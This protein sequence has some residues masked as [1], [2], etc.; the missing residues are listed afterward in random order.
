MQ[1]GFSSAG[2]VGLALFSRPCNDLHAAYSVQCVVGGRS[3]RL[4]KGIIVDRPFYAIVF[5]VA[6]PV[7]SASCTSYAST[8]SVRRPEGQSKPFLPLQ[9]RTTHFTHGRKGS[10]VISLGD[11]PISGRAE[12]NRILSTLAGGFGR[13]LT[14]PHLTLHPRPRRH[15]RLPARLGNICSAVGW[16]GASLPPP[17]PRTGRSSLSLPLFQ[18]P[19]HQQQQLPPA[20]LLPSPPRPD[21]S[22][23]FPKCSSVV[24]SFDFFSLSP[25]RQRPFPLGSHPP[26]SPAG[27]DP[28]APYPRPLHVGER[29]SRPPCSSL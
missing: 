18:C 15:L 3:H 5:C 23:L 19:H 6:P 27:K 2:W 7:Q 20:L 9:P 24:R 29:C 17:S 1:D 13:N 12:W 8:C 26:W 11:G 14:L 21:E 10:R 25:C 4:A 28:P 22:I 16:H